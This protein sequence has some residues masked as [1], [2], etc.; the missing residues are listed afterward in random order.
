[1][2]L[3]KN[4]LDRIISFDILYA[5]EFLSIKNQPYLESSWEKDE[6]VRLPEG[7]DVKASKRVVIPF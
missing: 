3:D 5:N 6:K 4:L 1:L 2:K 7:A